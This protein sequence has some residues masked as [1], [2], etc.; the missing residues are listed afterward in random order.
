MTAV[1]L[2]TRAKSVNLPVA[3]CLAI[4]GV[5][6]LVVLF[7]G[8]FTAQSPSATDFLHTF[9]GPSFSHVFGTDQLGRD[10][11][12]RVVYGAGASLK[13][14]MSATVIGVLG[15]LVIGALAVAGGRF[16]AGPLMRLVDVLLA[17]PEI[18]LA[19]LV[20]AVIGGDAGG[21][22]IAIG[23]AAVPNYARLVYSQARLVVLAEYVEAARVVGARRSVALVRH[24]VP[25]I[26]GPLVVLATLGTGTTI[27]SAAGLSLLGLGP[28]PPAPEWG[29]M[30]ADG[31]DFL[32]I[33]WWLTVFPGLSV[34]LVVVTCTVLGR[35]LRVRAQR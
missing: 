9:E 16:A 11:Y 14:A 29:L 15:G 28:A 30:I 25:N 32:G 35:T 17:F 12:A 34:V 26:A 10:V 8:M 19:L 20:V 2:A 31:K 5:L 22:A 3:V 24:V 23:M 33:A 1:P 7:P 27:I 18:V 6:V 21:V 13:I 4:L